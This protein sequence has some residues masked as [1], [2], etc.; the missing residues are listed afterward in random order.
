MNT[1]TEYN[2]SIRMEIAKEFG[3]EAGGYAPMPKNIMP[4]RIAQRIVN[5]YPLNNDPLAMGVSEKATYIGQRYM[6][7][8]GGAK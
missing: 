7:L 1:Y 6:S 8:F 2:E 5:K 3:L 4:V